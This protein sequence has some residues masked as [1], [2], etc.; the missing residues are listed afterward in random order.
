M[1][2]N[3]TSAPNKITNSFPNSDLTSFAIVNEAPVT[4]RTRRVSSSYLPL[5]WWQ[6]P[7]GDGVQRRDEESWNAEG[8]SVPRQFGAR[9][10]ERISR[11]IGIPKIPPGVGESSHSLAP[12]SLEPI[13]STS[14]RIFITVP[15][16]NKLLIPCRVLDSPTSAVSASTLSASPS[17]IH[18]SLRSLL[19]YIPSLSL[20]S[21]P[22]PSTIHA[23]HTAKAKARLSRLSASSSNPSTQ[24][25]PS[26]PYSDATFLA[27]LW[28]PAL[29]LTAAAAAA[30]RP[31][32]SRCFA[33]VPKDD[34]A[35]GCADVL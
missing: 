18:D 5:R 32:F 26:S 3:R 17:S 16:T 7:R 11:L 28:L 30:I 9:M 2:E 19:P 14:H 12:P 8:L 10:G 35:H 27:S 1:L 22:P 23:V 15:V 33:R 21:F 4:K 6:G 24:S 34:V 20:Y 13:G 29:P 31:S 25:L